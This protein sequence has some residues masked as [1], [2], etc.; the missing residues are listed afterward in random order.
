MQKSSPDKHQALNKH[1]LAPLVLSSSFLTC[2]VLPEAAAKLIS[3]S[4]NAKEVLFSS[5]FSLSFK[6][7]QNTRLDIN[8]GAFYM[9]FY[10]FFCL[11][12]F[13]FLSNSEISSFAETTSVKSPVPGANLYMWHHVCT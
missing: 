3:Y 7:K 13:Y 5:L 12:F 11:F 6:L 2:H 9:I 1:S 10:L 8:D 4:N